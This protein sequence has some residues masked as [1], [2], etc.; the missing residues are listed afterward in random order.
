MNWLNLVA[1]SI[2][3]IAA[4]I[5]ARDDRDEIARQSEN[6]GTQNQTVVLKPAPAPAPKRHRIT[7]LVDSLGDIQVRQGQR[8]H[9]GDIISDMSEQRRQLETRRTQLQI[10]I[11]R[12]SLPLTPVAPFPQ[13]N[14]EQ[15]QVAL[16]KAQIELQQ[17]TIALDRFPGL[18]FTD[19]ELSQILEPDKLE[20]LATL[21]QQQITASLAVEAAI[22]RFSEAKTRY[23]ENHYQHSMQLARRQSELQKHQLD[24]LSLENQLQ[25]LEKELSQLAVRSPYSGRVRRIKILAQAGNQIKAEVTLDLRS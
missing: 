21:K 5:F 20:Q 1:I 23:Q 10:A 24:L 17:A 12:M 7:I 18:V 3:A 4:I 25:E 9:Q 19:I 22:A 13:P 11:Q 8:I 2:I 15:E 16:K 14:L 6:A